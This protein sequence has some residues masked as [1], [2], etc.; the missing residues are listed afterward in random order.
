MLTQTDTMHRINQ[1]AR[2]ALPATLID[3][4]P[5]LICIYELNW[6]SCT[7]RY[8]AHCKVIG[9]FV[10]RFNENM[11]D[12]MFALTYAHRSPLAGDFF[13]VNSN[14]IVN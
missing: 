4:V 10:D 3:L 7:C 13:S 1:P 14:V 6:P 9:R 2:V 5:R 11:A 12:V 8:F